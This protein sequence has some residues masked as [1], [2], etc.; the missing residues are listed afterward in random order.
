MDIVQALCQEFHLKTQ[1]CENVLRLID[2]GNT[3]PFIARY[4]K[5]QT[6]SLDDQLLREIYERLQYL[7]GLD[8]RRG[9]IAAAL[10]ESHRRAFRQAAKGRHPDRAGGPL[11]S[12]PAQAP[13][14]RH[15]RAGKGTGTA[16]AGPADAE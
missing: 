12:L 16:G 13:H 10:E 3:I 14:P 5:E 15:R 4:R 7:R 2:D 6:G 11:P 1:Q 8:K 9:E